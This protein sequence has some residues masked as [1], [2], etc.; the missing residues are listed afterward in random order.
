MGEKTAAALHA[1]ISGNNGSRDELILP[2]KL[3]IR[4]STKALKKSR[5]NEQ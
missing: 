1:Q 3:V 2:Y 4:E 5:E